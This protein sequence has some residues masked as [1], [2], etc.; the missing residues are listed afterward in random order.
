MLV[1][2]LEMRD[3]RNTIYLDP[4]IIGWSIHSKTVV[5]NDFRVAAAK[6]ILL[7]N[8]FAYVNVMTNFSY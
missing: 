2:N 4:S 7:K 6:S 8:V 1:F 5:G 3:V